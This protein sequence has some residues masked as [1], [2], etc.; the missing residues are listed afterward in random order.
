[1]S[2]L[3]SRIS[4]TPAVQEF[5]VS[6]DGGLHILGEAGVGH[7]GVAQT[8]FLGLGQ[9][10]AL[11]DATARSLGRLDDRNG[12]VILLDHDLYSGSDSFQHGVKISRQFGFGHVD[13]RRTVILAHNALLAQWSW[14]E[15]R[16]CKM[17]GISHSPSR[18]H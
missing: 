10:D 12:P 17:G 14:V 13:L 3:E 15:P 1:M 16:V 7:G 11:V 2:T 5:A 4:P 9:G 8:L 6:V 18:F